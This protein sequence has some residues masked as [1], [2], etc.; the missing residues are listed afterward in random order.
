MISMNVMYECNHGLLNIIVK[1]CSIIFSLNL[2]LTEDELLH[3]LSYHSLLKERIKMSDIVNINLKPQDM[4]T[5]AVF[6]RLVRALHMFL[7]PAAQE[8]WFNCFIMFRSNC[9]SM[10]QLMN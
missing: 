9:F 10:L 4:I 1:F 3:L 6:A 8:R 7:G 5:P 2:G